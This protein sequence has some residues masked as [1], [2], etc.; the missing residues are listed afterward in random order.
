MTKTEGT[1]RVNAAKAG[2]LVWGGL[3][4]LATLGGVLGFYQFFA[5]SG[6]TST[7]EPETMVLRMVESGDL[8]VDEAAALMDM[9]GGSNSAQAMETLSSGTERQKEALQLVAVSPTFERGISILET[10][11]KTAADWRLIAELSLSRDAAR[12]VKAARKAIAL[13]P[14]DFDT[15]GLLVKS[16]MQAGSFAEAKRSQASLTA[17]AQS[18]LEQLKAAII[19]GDLAYFTRRPEDAKSAISTLSAT[20]EALEPLEDLPLDPAAA[21]PMGEALPSAAEAIATRG[22]LYLVTEEFD[23]IEPDM[24][25]AIAILESGLAHF[26]GRDLKNARMNLALYNDLR[27]TAKHRLNQIDDHHEAHEKSI[28]QYR[29]MADAGDASAREALPR[30]LMSLAVE[31]GQLGEPEIAVERMGEALKR[32]DDYAADFPDNRDLKK[33]RFTLVAWEHMLG[34]DAQAAK[35]TYMSAMESLRAELLAEG[36]PKEIG[37]VTNLIYSSMSTFYRAEDR[38]QAL[39]TSLHAPGMQTLSAFERRYGASKE[40]TIERYRVR[41]NYVGTLIAA[42]AKPAEIQAAARELIAD[43]TPENN[44]EIKADTLDLFKVYALS[45]LAQTKPEDYKTAAQEGLN[46]AQSL[47]RKGKLGSNEQRY[48]A[49]FEAMLKA[50]EE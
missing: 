10:E 5:D 30:R 26:K 16:Q 17:I 6:S 40:L 28:A 24:Q 49:A 27:A 41:L 22:Q 32:F 19:Q 14:A 8:S 12:A 38:T 21:S 9:L 48:I 25:R 45:L 2:R 42:E 47:N 46:L 4:L 13:A 43:L 1:M 18:P 35:A 31:Y 7:P 29:A 37:Q 44:T 11:A 15:L 34:G 50:D 23:K 39:L 33:E 36:D 20:L 3:V